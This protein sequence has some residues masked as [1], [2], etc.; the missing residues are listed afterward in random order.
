MPAAVE[1]RTDAY[2]T[3]VARHVAGL[4]ER[5]RLNSAQVEKLKNLFAQQKAKYGA[6]ADISSI[7]PFKLG[8]ESML[9]P[10]QTESYNSYRREKVE[11]D[12]AVYIK[13]IMQGPN[14]YT[15]KL[16]LTPQQSE[17]VHDALV[18]WYQDLTINGSALNRN[19]VLKPF[20]TDD[21]QRR[22]AEIYRPKKDQ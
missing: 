17:S 1:R 11:Q 10:D 6:S 12:A 16:A 3:V 7:D 2:D 8:I 21:Q 4:T 19:Q 14:G 22:L 13:A 9:N 18:A 20:L 5:L 15:A